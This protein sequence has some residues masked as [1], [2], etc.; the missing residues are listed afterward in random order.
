MNK[1]LLI[2]LLRALLITTAVIAAMAAAA[3]RCWWFAARFLP[4]ACPLGRT[5]TAAKE[6]TEVTTAN[7]AAAVENPT[8]F[9]INPTSFVA[10]FPTQASPFVQDFCVTA[11]GEHHDVE[12]IILPTVPA[13]PGFDAHYKL[14]Y[15]NKGNQVENGN[16]SFTYDDAVLDYVSSNSIVNDACRSALTLFLNFC[17]HVN[18]NTIVS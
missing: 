5:P 13:R 1:Y 11:N 7:E 3:V 2:K 12:V 15:K 16:I 6:S 17:L 8:Y 4:G 18:F 14:V 10:N 9:N